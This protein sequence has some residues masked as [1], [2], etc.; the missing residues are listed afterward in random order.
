MK[1][2]VWCLTVG[3]FVEIY[4]L[5]KVDM[6][7]KCKLTWLIGSPILHDVCQWYVF[8]GGY[9]I[10]IWNVLSRECVVYS[11]VHLFWI[12]EFEIISSCMWKLLYMNEYTGVL[13]NWISHL[14]FANIWH[15]CYLGLQF[16]YVVL[17]FVC[18]CAR[19]CVCVHIYSYL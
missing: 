6:S 19:V 3:D 2:Y 18:V 5:V 15:N 7:W 13:L 8:M 16:I 14:K 12:Y 4:G 11:T 10:L 17:V 9:I 1:L